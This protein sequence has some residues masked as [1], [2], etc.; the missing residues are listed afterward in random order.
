MKEIGNLIPLKRWLRLSD[1]S[2]FFEALEKREDLDVFK[3]GESEE[4]RAIR[5]IN[6]G[7]GPLKVMLWTQMH[8]NEPSATIALEPFLNQ[9]LQNPDL[10]ALESKLRVLMIP[11]L[12]PDGAERF[13]RRNAYGIDI[14]RDALAQASAEMQ[15]FQEILGSFRPDW[16]F[17]LHD[18]RSI[19]CVGEGAKLATLSFLAPS[20]E[21]SR[22]IGPERLASMQLTAA[23]HQDLKDQ[24]PGHFGRY[25]DEFYPKALGDNLMKAGISNI[26][27]EAGAYPGDPQREKA[28]TL[29]SAGLIS[30]LKHLAVGTWKDFSIEQYQAIPANQKSKRDLLLKAVSFKGCTL[31]LA[32]QKVEVPKGSHGELESLYQISDI[33]DLAE[34]KGSKELKGGEL[35]TSK[36]LDINQLAHF[37][38]SGTENLNFSNGQLQEH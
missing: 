30:A 11:M 9:L 15:V 10:K 12:N 21:E 24:L 32:L 38:F 26:L 20:A 14:N 37:D 35:K 31:D 8:G 17:N 1:L 7:N 6:W 33:G 29:T 23:I 18:Q 27:F 4:G 19:F 13:Q 2:T 34:L 5:A 36:D 3:I 22:A 25:T 16:A 28:I